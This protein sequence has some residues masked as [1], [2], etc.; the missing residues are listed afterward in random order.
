MADKHPFDVYG[1]R[2]DDAI[3]RAARGALVAIVIALLAV[4]TLIVLLT[5]GA[6]NPASAHA[7]IHSDPSPAGAIPALRSR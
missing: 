7:F 1:H 5:A 6:V 3:E 2:A 4:V